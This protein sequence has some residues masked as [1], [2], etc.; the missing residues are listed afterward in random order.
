MICLKPTKEKLPHVH[1]RSAPPPS[2]KVEAIGF[3]AD[4]RNAKKNP[5]LGLLVC[6]VGC[7]HCTQVRENSLGSFQTPGKSAR[8]SA[9]PHR[10]LPS[11]SFRRQV[12]CLTSPSR[13]LPGYQFSQVLSAGGFRLRPPEFRTRYA[14]HHLLLFKQ[15]SS[16]VSPHYRRP[17]LQGKEAAFPTLAYE[18]LSEWIRILGHCTQVVH[19]QRSH[20]MFREEAWPERVGCWVSWS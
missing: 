20:L 3:I 16:S 17:P 18:P 5:M 10:P 8:L 11:L 6:C 13:R 9:S 2:H 1:G 12:L 14:S 7:V 4:R 15:A 19:V